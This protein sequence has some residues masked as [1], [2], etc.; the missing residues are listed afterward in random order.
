MEVY[1][2]STSLSSGQTKTVRIRLKGTSLDASNENLIE[3]WDYINGR[4]IFYVKADGR[5]GGTGGAYHS[6]DIKLKTNIKRLDSSLAKSLRPV[7]FNFINNKKQRY[8]FIAQ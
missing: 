3:I 4:G 6:S 1:G 7:S 8:G 5:V 2:Y